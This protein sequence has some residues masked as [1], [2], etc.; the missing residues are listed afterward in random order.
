MQ[1]LNSKLPWLPRGTPQS[2]ATSTGFEGNG[3]CS[4]PSEGQWHCAAHQ[5]QDSAAFPCYSGNA[6]YYYGN[7]AYQ[8]LGSAAYQP[9]WP[10]S[11]ATYCLLGYTS[12]PFV[13][14]AL[15]IPSNTANTPST[16]SIESGE[17]T[18]SPFADKEKIKVQVSDRERRDLFTN[19]YSESVKQ[20]ERISPPP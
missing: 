12:Y 3:Q 11:S 20:K 18:Q 13:S 1:L 7:A 5:P 8:K 4:L 2:V 6:T 16:S 10:H 9:H 14:N 15:V 17:V 19:E